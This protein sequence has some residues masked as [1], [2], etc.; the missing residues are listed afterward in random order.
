MRRLAKF[1]LSAAS[2]FLLAMPAAA[3]VN[4]LACEPEWGSLA[5]ELGG[6]RV[7][8]YSATTALHTLI[9]PTIGDTIPTQGVC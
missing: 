4:V 7:N 1:F 9:S 5:A 3:A 2:L 8:V 6:E